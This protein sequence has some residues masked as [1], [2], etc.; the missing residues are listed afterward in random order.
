[1]KSEKYNLVTDFDNKV[2]SLFQVWLYNDSYRW[3]NL[4]NLSVEAERIGVSSLMI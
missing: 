2:T 4:H 1:M 3:L